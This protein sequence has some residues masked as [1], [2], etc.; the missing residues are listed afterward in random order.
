MG[1]LTPPPTRYPSA[2]QPAP[3]PEPI[4]VPVPVPMPALPPGP[5]DGG[6][7][8]AISGSPTFS[9]ATLI[10]GATIVGAIG[11]LGFSFLITTV[12]GVNCWRAGCG[13]APLEGNSFSCDPPP[14]APESPAL[15]T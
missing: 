12:G 9:G 4:P 7:A 1:G 2:Q 10:S 14:P 11:S 5:F 8:I 3:P 6:P 15:K 13:M